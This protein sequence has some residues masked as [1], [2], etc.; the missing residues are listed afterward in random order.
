MRR[1]AAEWLLVPVFALPVLAAAALLVWAR[2]DYAARVEPYRREGETL[3][4]R[5]AARETGHVAWVAERWAESLPRPQAETPGWVPFRHAAVSGFVR[6]ETARPPQG[7]W[8]LA[9]ERPAGLR[10]GALADAGVRIALETGLPAARHPAADEAT[11]AFAEFVAAP[12]ASR[13]RAAPLP[14]A[15]KLYLLRRAVPH[16]VDGDGTGNDDDDSVLVALAAV[17]RALASS[18]GK[19]GPGRHAVDG[20]TLMVPPGAGPALVFPAGAAVPV[21]PVQVVAEAPGDVALLV[22]GDGAGSRAAWRGHLDEPLAGE[23]AV[24]LP[25]GDRWWTAPGAQTWAVTAAIACAAFLLVPTA[26]LIALRRRRALDEARARFVNELAHDLRTPVTS[27][28][29]HAEMLA[30]GRAAEADRGR[31]LGVLARETARLSALLANLL[32]LSRLGR[33]TREVHAQS[34]DV[35]ETVDEAVREFALIH[36]K[37]AGDV[38]VEVLAGLAVRADRTSLARCLGNL[39]DNAG[40]FTPPGT[41][42]RVSAAR[43]ADGRV[44]IVVADE[45]EGI[46]ASDRE[47]VFRLYERGRGVEKSAVPGTGLGLTLVRELTQAMGGRVTL[48]DTPRGAAFEFLLEEAHGERKLE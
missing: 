25:F 45:G 19:L 35:A 29:L 44:R 43:A 11:V 26:L 38:S 20:V 40:K 12:V 36:P 39:L 41:A 5:W 23:W 47:R 27:L 2:E 28:R 4:R 8:V 21:A 1:T 46:A 3:A 32:D 42:I 17:E 31:Y 10:A 9:A 30:Q 13:L 14:A 22:W 33:G 6:V 16:G 48:L 24:V 15:T 34:V 18:R 7:P 37:R